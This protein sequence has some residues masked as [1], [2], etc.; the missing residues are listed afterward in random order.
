MRRFSLG[1]RLF[2]NILAGHALVFILLFFT[3]FLFSLKFFNKVLFFFPFTMTFVIFFLEL[4]VAFLQAYVFVV[5]IAIYLKDF[6]DFLP[7]SFYNSFLFKHLLT[8]FQVSSINL[9]K[10]TNNNVFLSNIFINSTRYRQ[11]I[12]KYL[13]K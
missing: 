6:V 10:E 9:S 1:I 11:Q 8:Y 4:L 2:A 7:Y 12:F 3:Y 5:L 13:I